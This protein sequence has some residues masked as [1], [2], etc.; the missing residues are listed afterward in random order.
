MKILK[1]FITIF[2][3]VIIT[4]CALLPLP[5]IGPEVQT[6]LILPSTAKNTSGS[7]Y[8]YYYQYKIVNI[9]DVSSFYKID[10]HPPVGNYLTV[11]H[12]P[13]GDYRLSSVSF[14]AKGTGTRTVN[15]RTAAAHGKIRLEAGKITIFD[16]SINITQKK[17]GFDGWWTSNY[18]LEGI[19][20]GHLS[21]ILYKLE[22]ERNFDQ[23]Q[24]QSNKTSELNN[25]VVSS[26]NNALKVNNTWTAL[27]VGTYRGE[28]WSNGQPTIGVTL[29]SRDSAKKLSGSYSF[30]SN[31]GLLRNC[32]EIGTSQ[33]LACEWKDKYGSGSM[34]V[35][36]SNDLKS[37]SGYWNFLGES[38]NF[39]WNGS[40]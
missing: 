18:S 16:T 33:E 4:S 1:L 17:K 14:I 29:F 12:I 23:W 36:F 34:K 40:R 28:I 35:V 20:S 38:D 26:S 3:V 30:G 32:L 37:F 7:N 21:A 10:I 24:L 22:H 19:N 9:D 11:D 15:N 8:G 13:P 5:P 39:V 27:A 31:T 6:I 25:S 2:V